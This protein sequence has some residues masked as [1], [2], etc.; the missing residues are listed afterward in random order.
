MKK[1]RRNCKRC[2][3]ELKSEES[4]ELGYGP[5][6]YSKINHT[7]LKPLFEM[8]KVHEQRDADDM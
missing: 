5:V 8:E 7:E 2:G 1:D 4:R 6:C 3:R